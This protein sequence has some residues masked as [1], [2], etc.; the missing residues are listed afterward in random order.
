MRRSGEKEEGIE[1][2][3]RGRNVKGAPYCVGSHMH[4][5]SSGLC[6]C[7]SYG[8]PVVEEVCGATEGVR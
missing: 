3:M 2:R 8:R 4:S 6:A 1:V 5:H 7:Q